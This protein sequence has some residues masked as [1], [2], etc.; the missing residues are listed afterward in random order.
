M[1]KE[2]E[3]S[4][5]IKR[6]GHSRNRKNSRVLDFIQFLT[7]KYSKEEIETHLLSESALAKDWL[8]ADEDRAQQN[9]QGM[10]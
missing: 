9:L 2:K 6:S 5:D 8:S 7:I 1:Q 3:V 4:H 10:M